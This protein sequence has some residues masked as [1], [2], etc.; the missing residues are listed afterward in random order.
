M[1][2]PLVPARPAS[3][4]GYLDRALGALAKLGLPV[5]QNHPAPILALLQDVSAINEV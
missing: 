4:L 3:A 2:A 1:T 5:R